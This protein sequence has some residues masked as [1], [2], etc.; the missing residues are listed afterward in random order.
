MTYKEEKRE[1]RYRMARMATRIGTN[2]TATDHGVTTSTVLA[3]CRE[4]DMQ[5]LKIRF[6]PLG[7]KA[8]AILASLLNGAESQS[9][10]A[11]I[12]NVNRQQVS[13]IY[14]EACVAGIKFPKR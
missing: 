2:L 14:K 12:H 11:V 8:Y 7:L 5:P 4:F 3:A 10:I 1:L 13:K 9:Q 6:R